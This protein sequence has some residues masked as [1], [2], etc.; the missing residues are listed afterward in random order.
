MIEYLKR[1]NKQQVVIDFVIADDIDRISRDIIGWHN[2]KNKIE[3]KGKAKIQTVKQFLEDT[4]EG[5][6][7][8]N[9]I[10]S[11]KQYE[12]ENNTKRIISRKRARLL[13]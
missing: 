13:D 7:M 10:V 8:Q 6:L 3:V 5:Q 4:P 9:I 11:M 2:I 12:R 1:E